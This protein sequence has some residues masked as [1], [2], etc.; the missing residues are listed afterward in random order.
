MPP[1]D[2]E[3]IKDLKSQQSMALLEQLLTDTVLNVLYR[4]AERQKQLPQLICYK[5][6]CL[7]RDEIP[8]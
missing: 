7:L 3:T 5:S 4:L 1:L 2:A 8:F 6:D